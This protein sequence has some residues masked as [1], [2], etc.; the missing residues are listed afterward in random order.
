MIDGDTGVIKEL[1]G[2]VKENVTG[3]IIRKMQWYY[4]V[5]LPILQNNSGNNPCVFYLLFSNFIWFLME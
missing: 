3:L 5:F 1:K 2:S 4:F